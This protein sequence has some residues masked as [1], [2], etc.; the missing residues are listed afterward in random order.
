MP[1]ARTHD[2]ITVVTGVALAPVSYGALLAQGHIPPLATTGSLIF[3][4]AHLLSGM[5]FSPDLDID[6]SIDNRW[7]PL[8]WI[9]RPYMWLTPHRRWFSHGLILPPLLRLV[10]FVGILSLVSIALAWLFAQ[11]GIVLPRYHVIVIDYIF[12]LM[13]TH[14][15]ESWLVTLG[16]ITGGAAHTIADWLSTGGK[17]FAR[18]LG[19]RVPKNRGGDRR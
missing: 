13:S 10:Y 12:G 16:F 3:F 1:N 18:R 19:L 4:G 7:G 14:P 6:S 15:R 8:Y 11:I 9:W 2:V 17:R 5:M